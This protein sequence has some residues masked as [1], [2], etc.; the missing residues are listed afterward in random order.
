M[1]VEVKMLDLT[2]FQKVAAQFADETRSHLAADQANDGSP[3]TIYAIDT[4]YEWDMGYGQMPTGGAD[5]SA[6]AVV[7]THAE[8]AQKVVFWTCE[9][10]GAKPVLPHWD[11]GN[12][13]EILAYKRISPVSHLLTYAGK[14]VWRVN[15]IYL[16]FLS[17]PVDG[18]PLPT[19]AP[20][21]SSYTYDLLLLDGSLFSR[22]ILRSP[23]FRSSA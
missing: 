10:V 13:N 2:T 11:T 21:P 1:T 17:R 14:Q 16:Y 12:A 19:G 8:V 15:G 7:K 4:D 20:P 18:A 5:G 22:A 9:R 23:V 3:Y 6:S